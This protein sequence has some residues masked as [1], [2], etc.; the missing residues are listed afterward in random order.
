MS[1]KPELRTLA[2]LF[3]AG[4]LSLSAAPLVAGDGVIEINQAAATAGGT[5]PSDEP[6]FPITLDTPGSYR[7]TGN[8]NLIVPAEVPFH[9]RGTAIEI[10]ADDVT[11]DLA[12]FHISVT[13]LRSEVGTMSSHAIF[14]QNRNVHVSG[15]SIT[16]HAS[17]E[18][19]GAL[20][21]VQHVRVA[22]GVITLWGAHGVIRDSSAFHYTRVRE[23]GLMIS[24]QGNRIL[25][26]NA[27]I[28][29]SM[30]ELI[31]TGTAA[32]VLGNVAHSLEGALIAESGYAAY[33]RNVLIGTPNVQGTAFEL[34]TNVCG[35]DTTCP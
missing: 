8:I 3:L 11:L 33:G 17:V 24:N 19:E 28:M 6:G 34:G 30:V 16:G 13:D 1:M 26:D 2:A 5:T 18:L 7:L 9:E 22:Q 21:S 29:N 10:T 4:V 27:L 23:G 15:G 20:S 35:D 14:S 31:A 32:L 12:G 25:G